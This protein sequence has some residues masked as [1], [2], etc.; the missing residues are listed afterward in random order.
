MV[1]SYLIYRRR[2][3]QCGR[4]DRSSSEVDVTIHLFDMS[5][6]QLWKCTKTGVST[7]G[8]V[9]VDWDLAIGGGSRLRTGV[10]IYRIEL[11]GNGGLNASHANKLIVLSNN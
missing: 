4:H 5:G 2:T 1:D 8:T 10:Y 3:A 6:R 7:D 11:V 9:V